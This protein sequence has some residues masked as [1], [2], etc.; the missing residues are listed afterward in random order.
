MGRARARVQL[1]HMDSHL[2][3]SRSFQDLQ[4]QISFSEELPA[5]VLEHREG[6]L[7][8]GVGDGLFL[9]LSPSGSLFLCH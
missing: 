7:G 3:E 2:Q 1:P 4:A 5:K 9:K 6:F 8:L